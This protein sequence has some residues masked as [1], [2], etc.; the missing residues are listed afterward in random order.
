MRNDKLIP[1]T[2]LVIIGIL[3]LLN[4]INVIDFDWLSLIRL[5]PIL[6]VI[7]GV[8]LIFANN[9]TGTATAIKIVVLIVGMG[10]LIATGLSHHNYRHNDWRYAFSQFDNDNDT[11]DRDDI[12][13]GD[14]G[15]SHFSEAYKPAIEQA[16][17]NINGGV[18]T[19]TISDTT[20][21]LFEADTKAHGGNYNLTTSVDSVTET[22][23]FGQ[24]GGEN[25]HR[26]FTFNFGNH[27]T[28]KA[29]IKLN[30]RPIW[31][32][33]V[34][35]GVSNVNF[36]LSK[37]KVQK[38][39]IQG[40]VA[41]FKVKMG[42]PLAE[43]NIEVETGISNFT[44]DIPKNAACH[45]TSDSELSSKRLEGFVNVSDNEYETPGFEKATNKINVS[46]SGGLSKFRVTQY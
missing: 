7:G 45:I 39:S 36:D 3:F 37:F 17:L 42:Q 11:T 34:E 31:E 46:L 35:T 33:N 26:G 12:H 22:L 18:T 29:F 4:S 5:W 19:Y 10:I 1:G 21:N 40:G 44:L 38:I 16:V 23:D 25:H 32:I 20:N 2:V 41:S 14:K 6:L 8:N 43:T 28:N 9:R 13:I 27:S 30:T 15:T 24:D